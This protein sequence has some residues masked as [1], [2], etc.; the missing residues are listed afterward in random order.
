[1]P[2]NSEIHARLAATRFAEG[3]SEAELEAVCKAGR[4]LHASAGQVIFG[5]G[6]VEDEVFVL[7]SGHI[8]LEMQVPRRGNVRLLT[9][10]AGE[11][12][13][14]S[15]LIGDGQMTATAIVTED[16]HLIG[17]SSNALKN[18]CSQD[19]ELG[20]VLMT[21]TAKAIARRLL[22]T[23]LQLLDLFSE[24]EPVSRSG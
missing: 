5:E 12:V 13:G 17:L 9:V 8:A 7:L 20:Y 11:L 21:R 2:P 24:T 19:H 15:G 3:F 22:A 10:G 1:M 6:A 23:R 16:C 4:I 14:W 18:L